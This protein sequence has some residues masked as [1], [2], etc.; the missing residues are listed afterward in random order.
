MSVCDET[1]LG[2]I[3]LRHFCALKIESGLAGTEQICKFGR[4]RPIRLL[5]AWFLV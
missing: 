3:L 2:G 5:C 4:G 1:F